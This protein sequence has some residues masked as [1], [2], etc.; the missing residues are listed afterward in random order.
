MAETVSARY[1]F[2]F[3][4]KVLLLLCLV[5]I[6]LRLLP[7][8]DGPYTRFDRTWKVLKFDGQKQPDG[9]QTSG[10]LAQRKTHWH[11]NNM[12]WNSAWDYQSERT[13]PL[14]A[15]IGNS[16]VEGFSLDVEQGLAGKMQNRLGS[17]WDCYS[18]GYSG[19]K[20]GQY[21]NL[22]R[23]VQGTYHPRVMVFIL[24]DADV[25]GSL[26]GPGQRPQYTLLF[27]K[28]AAGL[29]EAPIREFVPSRAVRLYGKMGFVRYFA[30]NKQQAFTE[31][32]ISKGDTLSAG[33][34][35]TY[36]EV[37]GYAFGRL[38]LE[39]PETT[40]LMVLDAPR[41]DLYQGRILPRSLQSRAILRAHAQDCGFRVL[42]LT[43]TMT[44]L[45]AGNHRKFNFENDY[46][47]NEYGF[48]VVADQITAALAEAGVV[49]MHDPVRP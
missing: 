41:R 12:G 9:L 14:L 29:V 40:I 23:Y 35:E 28:T 3:L 18:F 24:F 48:S 11:I 27:Q 31:Q 16:Y 38:R 15:I 7:A 6:S 25:F 49:P 1:L 46:H 37:V 30:L 5:E 22:S 17:G 13:K 19:A 21:L 43:Q 39:N 47:W 42:D 4:G 20:L 8:S 34:I 45:Y 2:R 10:N 32:A 26:L 44:G 33:E 36:H